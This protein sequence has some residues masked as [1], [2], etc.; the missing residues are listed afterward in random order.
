MV[1]TESISIFAAIG[2]YMTDNR[3]KFDKNFEKN[4]KRFFQRHQV[5]SVT[6][7]YP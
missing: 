4:F 3:N 2:E 7:T 1:P 6:K 5:S